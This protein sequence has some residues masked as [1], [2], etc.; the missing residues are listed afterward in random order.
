MLKTK[1]FGYLRFQCQAAQSSIWHILYFSVFFF[2]ICHLIARKYRLFVFNTTPANYFN[3]QVCCK[4]LTEFFVR[5]RHTLTLIHC[6]SRIHCA[7]SVS[8]SSLRYYIKD[9][10]NI[11][12][13][14][15]FLLMKATSCQV[16]DSVTKNV[17]SCSKSLEDSSLICIS[18]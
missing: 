9:I 16:Y 1:T 8:V 7:Q 17:S 13:F 14:H 6:A 4:R 10:Y 18:L 11:Y 2:W 12:I 3:D 15:I 5:G